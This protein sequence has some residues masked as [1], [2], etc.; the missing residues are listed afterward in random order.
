M[1]YKNPNSNYCTRLIALFCLYVFVGSFITQNGSVLAVTT[2]AP[3]VDESFNS[4]ND[5]LFSGTDAAVECN[6][7]AVVSKGASG[8]VSSLVKSANLQTI[9][10]A[11]LDGGMTNVQAAA[12][13]GN[14]WWE[15]HFNSDSHEIG[16]DIGYGLAMWSFGRRTQLEAFA[17]QKGV[18]NSDVAMQM[19]FLFKEYNTSYKNSLKGTPFD[20]SSDIAKATESWMVIFEVPGMTPPNDPAKLNSERIPAAIKIYGFYKD[21]KGVAGAA[22]SS[23][24]AAGTASCSSDNGAVAGSIVDTALGFALES[25]ATD[26]MVNKSDA[27]PSYQT[28]KESINPGGAWSD[29]G[30]FVA[31]VMIASGVDPNYPKVGTSNQISYV[32][33]QP[34]KY[35]IIEKPTLQAGSV[36]T[37]QPG[38][39]LITSGHTEIYTGKSPYP[40]VDASL[41]DRVPSV[42]SMG[43]LTWMLGTNP[44]AARI[45]K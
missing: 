17:K 13:M 14:M 8:S 44:I 26:G 32:R 2:P 25:T 6:S 29:C 37:L 42:G 27:K 3:V 41:N 43:S 21:L 11:L 10:Q 38:D 15:S 28:A 36:N 33:S 19:E 31:T 5:V 1:I 30:V 20:T 9:F 7:G 12:V 4:G 16:N 39:I 45:I 23:G 22:V 35:Q 24:G 34:T 18:P 40:T